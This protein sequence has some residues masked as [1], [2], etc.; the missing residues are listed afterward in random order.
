MASG[1]SAAPPSIV[2]LA[3]HSGST[4]MLYH[5][6]REHFPIR[7]IV[8]EDPLPRRQ[9]LMRRAKRLGI[10]KVVGQVLF[11]LL[12]VPYLTWRS[13]GRAQEIK[14]L[15]RLE[16]APLDPDLVTRVSSVNSEEARRL[17][18]RLE[19][20]VVL[21]N[22][23]RIV[24]GETLRAICAAFLNVHAGITPKY[25]GVH[26]GYWALAEGE[27]ESCGVTVHLV[28]EGVDTGPV[29]AQTRIQPTHA[30]CFAT[31]PLLQLGAALP[32]LPE[33]IA[34]VAEGSAMPINPPTTDSRLWSHPTL[35]QYLAIRRRVG[36]G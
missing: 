34:R 9:F 16:D 19:P 32:L 30:D 23:T 35:R 13:K 8:I 21:I 36:I 33:A 18:R 25:R 17:L 24:S 26:G 1:H 4:R 22:G 6:L 28:D 31:Y 5:Y 14:A 15:H 27:P 20:D 12:V 3:Q 11:Q 29:L 10:R 7:Q 2:L